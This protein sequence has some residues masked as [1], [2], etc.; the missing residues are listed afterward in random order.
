MIIDASTLVNATCPTGNSAADHRLILDGSN[1]TSGHGLHL[2]SSAS[3]STIRGLSIRNFPDNGIQVDG[4]DNTIACNTLDNNLRGVNVNGDDNRIGG[5][6]RSERNVIINSDDSGLRLGNSATLNKVQ[7]NFIGVEGDGT[8]A[9]G[10]GGSG[11]FLSGGGSNRVGGSVGFAANVISANSGHG[12]KLDPGSGENQLRGNIIGL[13]VTGDVALG[14]AGSGI[15]VDGAN[16]NE[17][18]GDSDSKRNVIAAN[19]NNGIFIN[20]GGNV[21]Q[22]NYIGTSESGL[23]DRGNSSMGIRVVDGDSNVIGG[24]NAAAGNL[25]SG[26]DDSGVYVA[27][28]AVDTTIRHNEIGINAGGNPLGNTLNGVHLTGQVS[29]ALVRNN[30]IANNGKDGI[31]VFET[32]ILSNF[33][34]NEIYDNGE[35]G[36]DLNNDDVVNANDNADGDGGGNGLMNYPVILGA[37]A[38]NNSVTIML[39]SLPARTYRIHVYRNQSCDSSGNGEGQRYLGSFDVETIPNNPIV[40]ETAVLSKNF[41]AGDQIT[42]TATPLTSPI[43][44]GTSEFSACFTATGSTT[45]TYSWGEQQ[46][47]LVVNTT[48]GMQPAIDNIYDAWKQSDWINCPTCTPATTHLLPF[49]E[50]ASHLGRTNNAGQLGDWLGD[51]EAS[52]GGGCADASFAGLREFSANLLDD[53]APVSDAILFSDAPPVGNRRAFGLLLDQL[54]E[55]GVR[56][57]NVG[58]ALCNNE[59]LPDDVMNRLALLSGGQFHKSASMGEYKTDAQMAMNLAMSE[60]LFG[61]FIDSVRTFQFEVDSSV[62]TIGVSYRGECLTCTEVVAAPYIAPASISGSVTVELIDPDGHVVDSSTPGYQQLSTS[63]RGMQIMFETVKASDAGTWQVRV[64]GD[65]PYTIDVFGNSAVH[66]RSIGKHTAR[67][68]QPFQVG[69]VIMPENNSDCC[70]PITATLKLVGLDNAATI[71]VEL[72]HHAS[73]SFVFGG[74]ATVPTPGLYRL[75]AEGELEDGTKFMR[76]DPT[77]I[78]VR[79]H[80]MSGS[81]N[82]AAMPGSVRSISFELSND[83][84][85]RPAGATASKTFDLEL[86]SELGWTASDAIPDSVTLAAGEKVV[87]TVDVVIPANADIGLIEESVLV[88]VPQDDLS[89]TV[90][91]LVKTTVDDQHHI[92]LPMIVR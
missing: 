5:T 38:D 44:D 61:S 28:H 43:T 88:A 62:R 2:D 47:G 63:S 91:V 16:A 87:Y 36:I 25:I 66:M 30:S 8:T 50:S 82:Q 74:S 55:R 81:S 10:N 52:G 22:G 84:V 57:H 11:V 69:A 90:S 77:P 14:N 3:G 24:T 59:N 23:L 83:G 85:A 32:V 54:I 27:G 76:V 75:V 4:D 29:Q 34:L 40:Q 56:V 67:V 46:V 68:N 49:K 71:P 26:N 70:R 60:D 79:A 73:S 13:D 72:S 15:Y 37:F 89:A 80:G 51:F 65:G 33:A 78:R 7:G 6:A 48:A 9:A 17:I 45:Q 64:T 31:A 18:G 1:L 35:L 92:F 41:N 20:S 53:G 58:R 12:I 39:D 21:V 86:F 42:A 19:G